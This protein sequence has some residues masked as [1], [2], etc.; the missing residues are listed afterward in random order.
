MLLQP[1]RD[2]DE[3]QVGELQRDPNHQ[4]RTGEGSGKGAC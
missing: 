1:K 2:E 4:K 3:N